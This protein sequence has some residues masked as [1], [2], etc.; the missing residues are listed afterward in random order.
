MLTAIPALPLA[1]SPA[2]GSGGDRVQVPGRPGEAPAGGPYLVDGIDWGSIDYL[3]KVFGLEGQS[4]ATQ[5]W[6]A[7]C[8]HSSLWAGAA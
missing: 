1:G 2:R 3:T 6:C 8:A 5:R 7:N 4:T